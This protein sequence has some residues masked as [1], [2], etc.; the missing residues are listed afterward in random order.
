MA[1]DSRKLGGSAQMVGKGSECQKLWPNRVNALPCINQESLKAGLGG[2]L[3]EFG[4]NGTPWMTV[5]QWPTDGVYS[6][7]GRQK[8]H[9][10]ERIKN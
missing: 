4:V 10:T 1:W 7:C 8:G 3:E 9:K 6:V 2:L 5:A